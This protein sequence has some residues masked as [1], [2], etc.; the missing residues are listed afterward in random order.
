[1]GHTE[2]RVYRVTFYNQG[3]V[4]EVY[5]RRVTQGEFF[6]FVEVEDLLF[7]ERSKL[8]VDTRNALKGVTSPKLFKL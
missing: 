1:M 2:E 3:Q 5:A 6:G 8:V 4:Y 7:G